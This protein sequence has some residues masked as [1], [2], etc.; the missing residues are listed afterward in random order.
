MGLGNNVMDE[1]LLLYSLDNLSLAGNNITDISKLSQ[2][3]GLVTLNL[4]GN[5]ISNIAPLAP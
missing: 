5:M 1:I 4:S 2:L 3:G